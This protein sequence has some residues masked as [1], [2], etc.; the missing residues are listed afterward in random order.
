[1]L[2]NSWQGK[3]KY[4][5]LEHATHPLSCLIAAVG[6]LLLFFP[7]QSGS[8][9]AHANLGLAVMLLSVLCYHCLRAWSLDTQAHQQGKEGQRGQFHRG[10]VNPDSV[11]LNRAPI[12]AATENRRVQIQSSREGGGT[13]ASCCFKPCAQISSG[14]GRSSLLFWTRAHILGVTGLGKRGLSE[15]GG[16]SQTGNGRGSQAGKRE[17]ELS[18]ALGVELGTGLQEA[19]TEGG[20]GTR[21]ER[22]RSKHG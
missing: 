9:V 6:S 13:G 20:G 19:R 12:A 17:R 16:E 22:Q 14:G 21:L 2:W 11:L 5:V 1:M 10:P 3:Q 7:C 8:D 4:S 15:Q 18:W